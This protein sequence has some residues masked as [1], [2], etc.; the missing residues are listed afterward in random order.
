VDLDHPV[1]N[2]VPIPNRKKAIPV[3]GLLDARAMNK[4]H[5][6]T[7]EV[8]SYATLKKIKPGDFVKVARNNE[9]FWV[10]VTGFEKRRIHGAV[11][12][13]LVRKANKDLPLGTVIYFQKKNILSY[14]PKSSKK[15]R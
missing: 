5:P 3:K 1:H 6:D 8:P 15:K 13:K 9:R 14:L 12:N 4:K 2:A 7:F 11:D 10:Q